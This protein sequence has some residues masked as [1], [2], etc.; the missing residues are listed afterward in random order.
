MQLNKK[1]ILL[2]ALIAG[3]T[4]GAECISV[5]DDAVIVVNV[6][7]VTGHYLIGQGTTS[8]TTPNNCVTIQPAD[9]INEDYGLVQNGRLVDV[10]VKANGT[11]GG[12][13]TGGAVTVNGVNL[14][15]YS[16]T[17]TALTT[18]Q[19]LLS[20]NSLLTKNQAGVT[21]LLSAVE[22]KQ[23]ITLC[24]AGQFSQPAAANLSVDVTVFAQVDVKPN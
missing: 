15:T 2:I 6:E 13:V 24:A 17:W 14:V 16:G 12:S 8:F 20:E 3:T 22:N 19:S 11:F 1:S 21:T 4:M 18:E 5:N 9:Y 7:N 10:K 23:T